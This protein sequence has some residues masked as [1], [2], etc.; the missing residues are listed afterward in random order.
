MEEIKKK[1]EK[2]KR[3]EVFFFKCQNLIVCWLFIHLGTRKQKT[4]KKEARW[5]EI[6]KSAARKKEENGGKRTKGHPEEEI[7]PENHEILEN[8]DFYLNEQKM[9]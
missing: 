1:D 2:E 9:I 7:P 3:R 8:E 6:E 4:G 5:R